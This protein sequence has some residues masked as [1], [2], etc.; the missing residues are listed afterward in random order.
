ML[1]N[2]FE[3]QWKL[4]HPNGKVIYRD[5]NHT[6][7]PHLENQTVQAFYVSQT[8]QND[9]HRQI[10]KLSNDLIEELKTADYILISSPLYN[11]NVPSTLKSYLDHIVRSE[12]TFHVNENGNYIGLL[13]NK[14]T[15]IITTKGETYAGTAMEALDFQEPYLKAITSFIGLKLKSIFALEATA[16]PETLQKNIALQQ[17]KISKAL[18][19]I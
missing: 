9:K 4:K 18:A 8:E 6:P 1:A 16:Y 11:L 5:L 2:F 14:S 10:L 3:T 19:T 13:E 7:I 17:T 15:F 12:V